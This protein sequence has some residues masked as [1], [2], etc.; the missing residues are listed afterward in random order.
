MR[1]KVMW[2]LV[3]GTVLVGTAVHVGN[4]LATDAVGFTSTT[5]AVG[6]VGEIDVDNHAVTDDPGDANAR[7]SVWL[8]LQKTK[9]DSD[10]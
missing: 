2:A 5:I 6:R 8:S 1:R 4:V 9:G 10:L 3:V 7:K